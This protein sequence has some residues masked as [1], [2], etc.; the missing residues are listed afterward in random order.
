MV[1]LRQLSNIL[2][3][4]GVLGLLLLIAFRAEAQTQEQREFQVFTEELRAQDLNAN[5]SPLDRIKDLQVLKDAKQLQDTLKKGGWNGSGGGGGVA[6]R[7]DQV[8][9][10]FVQRQELDQFHDFRLMDLADSQFR[11]DVPSEGDLPHVIESLVRRRIGSALPIFAEA[12]ISEYRMVR[13]LPVRRVD[14]IDVQLDL[15]RWVAGQL[16]LKGCAYAQWILR[17]HAPQSRYPRYELLLNTELD[18]RLRQI[19]SPRV[20]EYQKETLYLHEAIYGLLMHLD[21]EQSSYATR[22]LIQY[23][24]TYEADFQAYLSLGGYSR[25]EAFWY[26]WLFHGL[27][28]VR[29]ANERYLAYL[30]SGGGLSATTLRW[31]Q[32]Y[33]EYLR[34]M[35]EF[36]SS[37]FL[38]EF[39]KNQKSRVLQF[40]SLTVMNPKHPNF[41]FLFEDLITAYFYLGNH[42]EFPYRKVPS[43]VLFYHWAHRFSAEGFVESPES[44]WFQE[45]PRA[46]WIQAVCGQLRQQLQ[47]SRDPKN[48]SD[49][50]L[51]WS[52]RL[53]MDSCPTQGSG[54]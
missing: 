32:N 42:R 4:Q 10:P 7:M 11:F 8:T 28:G 35:D 52:L 45:E 47:Q 29:G 12:I 20:Y 2:T 18:L 5:P 22:G 9:Q 14:F 23:I 6:C 46:R 51:V 40:E 17:Y 24:L 13:R 37:K 26:A 33:I 39:I 50:A 21:P 19:L 15:A 43:G 36:M 41:R 34:M 16:N 3:I 38:S 30:Q 27:P 54:K 44:I 1:H 31:G 48:E 25:V 49:S 53:A